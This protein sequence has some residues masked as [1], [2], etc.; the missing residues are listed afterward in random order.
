[1]PERPH[2]AEEP[3]LGQVIRELR[4]QRRLSQGELAAQAGVD[5]RRLK[6]LESGR[7]DADYVM[8][9]RL[10]KAL[11]VPPGTVVV[12]AEKLA[13]EVKQLG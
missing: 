9:V 8:L 13:G 10:A 2:K 7:I 4:E 12:R 11:G 3:A 6:A 1:L 5:G